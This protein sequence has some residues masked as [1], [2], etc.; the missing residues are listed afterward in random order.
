MPSS[1]SPLT[2]RRRRRFRYSIVAC[3]RW[4][5]EF[6]CEWLA[7]HRSIGF[8]HV[9]LYC[10]DDDPA[11]LFDRVTPFL[12]GPTPFV[13]FM[14]YPFKGQQREIYLHHLRHFL[15]ESEWF[16][17]LDIDE[18]LCIRRAPTIGEYLATFPSDC[19]C[20]Y[21]NWVFYGNNGFVDRPG[22]S[23]L[24]QYTRR[25]P[26]L[27]P[28][29]KHITKSASVD[30]ASFDGYSF[31]FWHG[32]SG[33]NALNKRPYSALGEPAFD[34]YENFP[35]TAWPHVADR[36]HEIHAAAY[37][38]HF[39]FKSEAGF[40]LR[41]ERGTDGD[42][43]SQGMWK[44]M[45]EAGQHVDFLETVNAEPDEFLKQYWERYLGLPITV[46]PRVEAPDT[47]S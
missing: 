34:Y 13:D 7:Y 27:D 18:F 14:H 28:H 30:A 45:F 46:L 19:N 35:D 33:A 25:Q 2:K 26:A 32:W 47:E 23:V 5:Q 15:G 39:A 4:E 29:T 1:A 22:G 21:F 43:G 24:L 10:N 31:P 3:A 16:S 42:F 36:H 40:V 12:G 44:E 6:I 20:V 11:P 9:Y 17:Y 41:A 38:A 37:V 8:D